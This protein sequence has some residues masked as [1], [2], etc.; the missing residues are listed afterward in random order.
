M[1]LKKVQSGPAGQL[2]LGCVGLREETTTE[3]TAEQTR[4][5]LQGSK[6]ETPFKASEECHPTGRVHLRRGLVL[7]GQTTRATSPRPTPAVGRARPGQEGR[8]LSR[9]PLS[10]AAI[11]PVTSVQPLCIVESYWR[12]AQP[13]GGPPVPG[14]RTD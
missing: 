9:L 2:G 3:G 8:P 13:V 14:Q 5:K 6:G 12:L 4:H 1:G 7:L 11:C 10:A